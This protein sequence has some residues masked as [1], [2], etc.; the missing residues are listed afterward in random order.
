MRLKRPGVR[1][2]QQGQHA[3][4]C[5]ASASDQPV[6]DKGVVSVIRQF[7]QDQFLPV[8]LLLAMFI[9]WGAAAVLCYTCVLQYA[10]FG[11]L[12]CH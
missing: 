6:A 4:Q 9:G 10:W 11:K 5:Q 3:V 2:R 8:G 7:V 12:A 1:Q